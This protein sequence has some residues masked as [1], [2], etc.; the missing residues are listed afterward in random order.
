MSEPSLDSEPEPALE[1]VKKDRSLLYIGLVLGAVVFGMAYLTFFVEDVNLGVD[2]KENIKLETNA[3]KELDN[4]LS[5]DASEIRNSLTKFIQ[6]FYYDQS[7]GY[8]DPPSY[9]ANITETYYNYHN[10]TYQRLREFHQQRISERSGLR[11]NWIVSTLDF[12][13][14]E[15]NRLRA[16]YIVKTD[17]LNTIKN[18]YESADIKYEM[19]INEDGKIISLRELE[20]R[21]FSSVKAPDPLQ[22][23][24]SAF[25]DQDQLPAD[26]LPIPEA[27]RV[28]HAETGGRYEGRVYDLGTVESAPEYPGGQKALAQFISSNTHYP[29]KARSTGIEGRVY[30]S[31]I[32]ERNGEVNGLQVI[33]GIGG[34]CDEEAIR[35][36]RAT[37]PW[38][39][40]TVGGKPVRTAYTI[41]VNFKLR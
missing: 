37:T 41:P 18:A 13:H 27:G 24:V 33:R 5:M 29:A 21:N 10:L 20:I 39:P 12:D 30:V 14:D 1:N 6:A 7:R 36:L 28:Q 3:S 25:G 19:V 8:F 9:F 16:T 15:S 2:K 32:V 38:K 22:D 26:A 4:S 40:G 11:Q 34:G 35:V 31:F 23:S 17:Y